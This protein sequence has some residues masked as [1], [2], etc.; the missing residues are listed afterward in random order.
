[1][2][3]DQF[4]RMLEK[5]K[6]LLNKAEDPA[7]T[8]FEAE[9]LNDKA[10]ELIARYGIEAAML[11]K[12][13]PA[14]TEKMVSLRMKFDS[15][16]SNQ[17][18]N[19]AYAIA[20]AFRC[21]AIVLRELDKSAILRVI[22]YQ[23]DVRRTEFLFNHLAI[24][25]QIGMVLAD[26]DKPAHEHAK[27]WRTSWYGG[28]IISVRERLEAMERKVVNEATTGD[29]G[30]ALMVADRSAQVKNMFDQLYPKT[31]KL[32]SAGSR[33]TGW[34]SGADS[35]NRADIG[36]GRIGNTNKALTR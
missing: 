2:E 5:V 20:K 28:F 32:K 8:T 12:D 18:L 1:M 23:S 19:L 26:S 17:K 15:P 27:A 29:P 6:K 31:R 30:T 33:G 22:G 21:Q 25:A 9:A 13:D 34:G 14:K 10:A 35:G 3:D 7:C 16:Y 24:Q 11:T 4:S 36:H